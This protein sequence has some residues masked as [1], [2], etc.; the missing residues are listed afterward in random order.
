MNSYD[1]YIREWTRDW[2]L[3]ISRRA[4][5]EPGKG[6]RGRRGPGNDPDRQLAEKLGAEYSAWLKYKAGKQVPNSSSFKVIHENAVRLG[7]LGEGDT[8]K[9]EL[10]RLG[11]I[12]ERHWPGWNLAEATEGQRGCLLR[13]SNPSLWDAAVANLARAIAVA[14]PA[15]S[16]G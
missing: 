5:V 4:G 9:A 1:E 2:A 6:G 13:Q 3:R 8:I 11:P 12:E 16:S 15:S 10:E 7:F 14:V